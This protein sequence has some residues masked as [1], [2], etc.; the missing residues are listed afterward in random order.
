MHINCIK[1]CYRSY[2]DYP[3]CFSNKLSS[4]RKCQY[5]GIYNTN[6][7]VSRVQCKKYIKAAKNIITRIYCKYDADTFSVNFSDIPLFTIN[8]VTCIQ[9]SN[10]ELFNSEGLGSCCTMYRC[11]V[12]RKVAPSYTRHSNTWYKRLILNFSIQEV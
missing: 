7:S 8:V 3:T 11:V 9:T 12:C 10:I 2:P 5:T 1:L 4:S 6:T